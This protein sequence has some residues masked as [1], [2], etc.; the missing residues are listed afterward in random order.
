M[1]ECESEGTGWKKESVSDILLICAS[2]LQWSR[3][4]ELPL[5]RKSAL[6]RYVDVKNMPL[7]LFCI[8]SQMS[9]DVQKTLLDPGT[10]QRYQIKCFHIEPVWR[11][12]G[13]VFEKLAQNWDS[14]RKE[15]AGWSSDLAPGNLFL[16]WCASC[17]NISLC[18]QF[19]A[20][21][22]TLVQHALL[23]LA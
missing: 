7:R 17:W 6:H 10:L 21:H 3:W 16:H 5:R 2:L 13:P 12:S 22:L 11:G 4:D 8:S 14:K 18:Q 23:R 9:A 1:S 15:G 19:W 20:P